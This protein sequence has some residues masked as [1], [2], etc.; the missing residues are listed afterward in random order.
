MQEVSAWL[1]AKLSD[2][3]LLDAR[4]NALDTAKIAELKTEIKTRLLEPRQSRRPA[5]PRR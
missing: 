3:G 5:K 1:D 2:G 4:L